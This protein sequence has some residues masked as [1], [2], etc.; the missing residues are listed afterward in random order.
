MP[1]TPRKTAPAPVSAST[2]TPTGRDL[3]GPVFGQPQPTADPTTFRVPHASDSAAYKTIDKLNAEHKIE[4]LPFPAPRASGPEPILTLAQILGGATG[5]RQTINA[6]TSHGQIVFH[7]T[8]DCGSTKGP[9]TQ[10]L[11]TDKM[12]SDF[13]ETDAKEVPAFNFLLGDVVYSFGEAQYYF[14]QF[15]DPYR[16][17]PAPVLAVA[18][19]HDGMISPVAHA[20][21]LDAFLRNFCSEGFTITR[22]AGGLSR[23]AQ[24]QPGVFFTLEAPFVRIL[25]LYSNT[26][27]DPGVISGQKIG[28]T[29]LAFLQAAL[30]R[31]KAENFTGAILL[32]HHHPPYTVARHGWS[33]QMQTEIDGICQ[34][35]GIWPHADIAGHAHNYQRFTRTRPDGQQ[36]P[37]I[38]CGN[39]GHGLQKIKGALRAPQIIQKKSK[40]VD[41]IVLENYDDQDY[42]YLRIVVDDKQL[43]IEYH[44]AS[45]GGQTKTPD[46]SVTVDLG[47]RTIVHYTANDLGIPA[48]AK[49]VHKARTGR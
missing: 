18:G 20:Q 6:I 10:N 37:Y 11:V 14:D 47:T 36:I 15:Y 34:Q 38:V 31:A 8:G 32:A 21:S 41:Q 26:L 33:V 23:T 25:A 5:S 48:K 29:Q 28:G 30:Q 40:G 42:G 17:Y 27:E 9:S 35:V 2:P 39:G 19:N 45:D 44:P 43:R 22:D 1:K 3:D 7:S 16:D 24:I 12:L 46:D 13:D 4:P 49:A